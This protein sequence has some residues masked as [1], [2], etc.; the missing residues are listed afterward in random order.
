[1]AIILELRE[2]WNQYYTN[3][4][5]LNLRDSIIIYVYW[6]PSKISWF[7]NFLSPPPPTPH[8]NFATYQYHKIAQAEENETKFFHL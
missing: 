8:S 5:D 2:V 3:A 4:K 6:T 1:M 7:L